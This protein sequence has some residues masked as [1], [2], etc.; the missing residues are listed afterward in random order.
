MKKGETAMKKNIRFGIIGCGDV[1]EVK[2]GPAFQK[3]QGSEL[4]AVMRRRADLAE[5]YA[6]RH[7]VPRWY[8]DAGELIGDP[9]VDAIYIATP[10]SSHKEY[11]LAAA[12][13]GK[14]V[15]VEKPMAM[16]A[17]ECEE[18]LEACRSAGVP[19]FVAYYRRALPRFV[20]VKELLQ[21]G[22]I[23]EVRFVRT[24]HTATPFKMPQG[25]P[26]L[27]WR[28]DP[29]VSGG[30]LFLDLA[31][32]TLDLLDHL[33]GPV[34]E[35]QG[36]ASNQGRAYS[37]EDIVSGEFLYE[38]GVHG[39]G[40]W[41]FNSWE[42]TEYN[43]IV[44]SE[45]TIRF[46]TFTEAPVLLRTSSGEESFTIPHPAHVQ[47]PLVQTMVDELLGRGTCPST[48]ESAIRT[49]RVADRLLSGYYQGS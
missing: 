18:M 16:N 2:S 31:S 33:L 6:R 5:D 1:T 14:P 13:A 19:L 37:A 11:A 20:K 43:E 36:H 22:R 12:K 47:Q 49:S 23:G 4:A 15:Y 10:P 46:S 8:A 21:E 3:A 40:L 41:C 45:G 48:G 25:G 7:G 29:A 17:A 26:P 28:L 32:H 9:E 42:N 44:G 35:V 34:A 39:T 24:V 30:G 27:M 38:S